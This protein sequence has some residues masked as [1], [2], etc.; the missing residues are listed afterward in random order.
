M[1]SGIKLSNDKSHRVVSSHR[2]FDTNRHPELKITVE[3]QSSWETY[4]RAASEP[5]GLNYRHS[6]YINHLNAS[7]SLVFDTNYRHTDLT[8]PINK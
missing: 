1:F 7:S 2:K 6:T 3:S 4:C 5:A 8:A